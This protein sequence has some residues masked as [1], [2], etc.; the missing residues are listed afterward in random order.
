MTK[1]TSH[2]ACPSPDYAIF[3]D[4]DLL[5]RLF[6]LVAEGSYDVMKF[7]RQKKKKKSVGS[8]RTGGASRHYQLSSVCH[9]VMSDSLQ[10]HEL[11]HARRPCPSPTPG[12]DPNSCASSR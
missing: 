6:L 1:V 10:P 12:V 2:L 11:Q 4:A 9:S 7:L 5:Q 3:G 8:L